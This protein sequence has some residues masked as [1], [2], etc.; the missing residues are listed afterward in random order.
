VPDPQRL[1]LTL[2]LVRNAPGGRA[3]LADLAAHLGVSEM[4]VRRDLD[5]LQSR[6]LVRRVRGGAVPAAD[7]PGDGGFVVRAAWLAVTKDRIGRA[8]AALVPPGSTLLLDAGTTTL[9]VATHLAARATAT[10]G[11]T[12]M[13]VAVLGLQ[14]AVRLADVP[15]IRLVVL[16]G[17]AR[18]GEQSL[19]GPLALRAVGELS[20]DLFL[21]SIGGLSDEHGFSEFD[22]D[23]AAVK[24]AGLRQAARTVAVA[25][26]T[27][28]GVRAFASVAP[29]DAVQALVTD[30]APDGDPTVTALREAGVDLVLPD[31]PEE[32]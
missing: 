9:H 27:K 1:D 13:T 25:D 16:G 19:V 32:T 7:H 21:M 17:R 26:S 8:A 4:T 28:F 23:D 18:P 15:G 14:A 12:P 20:F 24:R 11:R 2:R 30:T 22:L 10:P 3:P 31:P 29:L 5:E 6:G